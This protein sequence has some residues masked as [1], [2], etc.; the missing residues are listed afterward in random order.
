MDTYSQAII[1]VFR[2]IKFWQPGIIDYIPDNL[3]SKNIKPDVFTIYKII[4]YRLINF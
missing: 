3:S 4:I 1:P 2:A